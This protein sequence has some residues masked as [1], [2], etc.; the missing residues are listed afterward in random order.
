MVSNSFSFWGYGCNYGHHLSTI[1]I[2]H[3]ISFKKY[4]YSN[5]IWVR[6]YEIDVILQRKKSVLL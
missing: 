6:L 3:D 2:K 5:N 4:Y 1:I